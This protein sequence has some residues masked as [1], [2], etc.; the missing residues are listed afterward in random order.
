MDVVLPFSQFI[1]NSISVVWYA[2]ANRASS[3]FPS[4]QDAAVCGM[5]WSGNEKKKR[6]TKINSSFT[7]VVVWVGIISVLCAFVCEFGTLTG[8]R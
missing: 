4:N 2:V 5:G 1:T 7:R 3:P 6:K 8:C